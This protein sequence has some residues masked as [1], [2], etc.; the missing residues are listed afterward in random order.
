MYII[1]YITYTIYA[2]MH[3]YYILIHVPTCT[4]DVYMSTSRSFLPRFLLTVSPFRFCAFVYVM[5]DCVCSFSFLARQFSL[6]V[7]LSRRP[8]GTHKP[9]LTA[10][11]TADT[12]ADEPQTRRAAVNIVIIIASDM[13]T[14]AR[15]VCVL[16]QS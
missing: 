6:P 8:G 14:A 9:S 11:L 15:L 12:R 7:F 10:L 2:S 5:W 1:Y 4:R 16:R 3:M 13:F